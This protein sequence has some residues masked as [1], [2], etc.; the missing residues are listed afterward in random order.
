MVLILD[1]EILL[2]VMMWGVARRK[3]LRGKSCGKHRDRL[4]TTL[5]AKS[6]ERLEIEKGLMRVLETHDCLV[7]RNKGQNVHWCWNRWTQPFPHK[8]KYLH[9]CLTDTIIIRKVLKIKSF[10]SNFYP[11]NFHWHC[12][13]F[14]KWSSKR[15]SD[16]C[17]T[18]TNGK[19]PLLNYSLLRSISGLL[20][21][22]FYFWKY[23]QSGSIQLPEE[24]TYEPL[25]Y[26]FNR[27]FSS[28]HCSLYA[29]AKV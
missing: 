6:I 16:V 15:F 29:L 9:L 14:A 28:S 19:T 3:D 26:I 5:K 17:S 25:T 2:L 13:I 7:Q 12:C 8:I 20:P 23:L 4:E 24:P 18:I 1:S 21:L 10:A 11:L 22:L 27:D